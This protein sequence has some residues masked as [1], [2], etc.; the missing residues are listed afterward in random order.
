MGAEYVLVRNRSVHQGVPTWM[1]D[2]DR[3]AQMTY[4]PQP[5]CS[6]KTLLELA[7]WLQAVDL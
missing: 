7:E 4:G 2:K 6:L 5:A 1:I 3:W